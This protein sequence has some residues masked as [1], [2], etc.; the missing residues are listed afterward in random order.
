MIPAIARA[1]GTEPR[2]PRQRLA[3][4]AGAPSQHNWQCKAAP[5]QKMIV[6]AG[7]HPGYA[8]MAI[9]AEGCPMQVKSGCSVLL[10]FERLD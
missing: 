1:R 4:T 9:P 3:L 5:C 7:I 10:T 8:D 6:E 2:G